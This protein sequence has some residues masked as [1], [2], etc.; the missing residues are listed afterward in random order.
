MCGLRSFSIGRRSLALPMAR[1][2]FSYGQKDSLF[3]GLP[4]NI[5]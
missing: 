2:S 3:K 4:T 5:N 1:K